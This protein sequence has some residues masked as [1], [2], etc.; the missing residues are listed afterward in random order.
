VTARTA[1][2]VALA[3]QVLA[4]LAEEYPLPIST[5]A[6]HAKLRPPCHGYPHTGCPGH[7]DYTA[8]YRQLCRLARRGEV[9]RVEF[10]DMRAV[11]WRRWEA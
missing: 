1:A 8:L 6:L 7:L 10:D 11:Y 2:N 3:D 9:E 4:A 5:P